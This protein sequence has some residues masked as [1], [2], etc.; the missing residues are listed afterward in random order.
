MAKKQAK[1]A[2]IDMPVHPAAA[3]FPMMSDEELDDLAADIKANGQVHDIIVDDGTLI[4]GRNR[5]VACKRAGVKPRFG[6]LNGIS[7]EAYIL[8]ANINRRHMTQVQSAMVVAMMYPEPQIGGK[9]RSRILDRL[10]GSRKGWKERIHQ[11]RGVLHHSRALAEQVLLGDLSMHKALQTV[12]KEITE[13]Q[14]REAKLSRIRELDGRLADLVDA[15][16]ITVPAAEAE[17]AERARR[18]SEVRE[19]GRE[20]AQE[21][22][23]VVGHVATIMSAIQLGETGLIERKVIA[24]AIEALQTLQTKGGK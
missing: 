16:E 14:S 12:D 15:E 22:R 7:A 9:G 20:A 5:L 24:K 11:A 10:G 19:H 8:S 1:Q 18:D 17:L 21:L 2:D 4:D 3:I 13:R 6:K 23:G